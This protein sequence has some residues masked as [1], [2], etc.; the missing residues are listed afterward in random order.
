MRGGAGSVANEVLGTPYGT[1]HQTGVGISHLSV[2][3]F[4]IGGIGVT[5]NT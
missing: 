3:G 5:G 4:R 2:E 1:F